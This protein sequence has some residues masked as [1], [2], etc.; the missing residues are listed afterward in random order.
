MS[1][2]EYLMSQKDFY[3]SEAIRHYHN[4]IKRVIFKYLAK[5]YDRELSRLMKRPMAE[6]CR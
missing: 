2:Y 1:R 6:V 4:P 3:T 5:K